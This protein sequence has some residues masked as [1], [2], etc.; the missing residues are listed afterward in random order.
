MGGVHV[1]LA[2]LEE[3]DTTFG[4]TVREAG[5]SLEKS[6]ELAARSDS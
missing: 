5:L 2:L 1:L 4:V 3:D 6:R